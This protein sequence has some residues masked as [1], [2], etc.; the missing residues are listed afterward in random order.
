MALWR[1][2]PGGCDTIVQCFPS[3]YVQIRNSS[4]DP[5]NATFRLSDGDGC[6]GDRYGLCGNAGFD[7]SLTG[8][9][10]YE[11]FELD[12]LPGDF[13]I[14]FGVG[15][16][17]STFN[18]GDLEDPGGTKLAIGLRVP[19][20]GRDTVWLIPFQ[21]H[22][23]E[24]E[25]KIIA[26]FAPGDNFQPGFGGCFGGFSFFQLPGPICAMDQMTFEVRSEP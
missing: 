13:S 17:R 11:A 23:A 25:S 19:G 14:A 18:V 24:F 6:D 2:N 15:K 20:E 21:G 10:W 12:D 22:M 8:P 4:C 9:W 26:E 16:L 7:I 1:N 5:I 3:V